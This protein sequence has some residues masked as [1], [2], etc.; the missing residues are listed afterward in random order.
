MGTLSV[1]SIGIRDIP[2]LHDLHS[3]HVEVGMSP[4]TTRQL[5]AGLLGSLPVTRRLRR[6]FVATLDD[7]LAALVELEPYPRD[8]RWLVT[9][10]AA[11]PSVDSEAGW[12]ELW[13]ELLLH[14]VR[15]AGQAGA[16]RLHA[17]P[18]PDG[19]AYE[20]LR[21]ASFN[22]YAQQT[23][24]LA[25]GVHLD[26]GVSTVVREQEPS[27]AWSIHQLYHVA[28]PY[29]IQHAEALTSNHW[30]ARRDAGCVVRGFLVD[31]GH[32]VAAYCRVRSRRRTHV[33]EILTLPEEAP[34]LASLLPESLRRAGVGSRDSVWVS[35]PDYQTEHLPYLQSLGFRPI[36]RQARMVRY[37]AVPVRSRAMPR[38]QLVPEVGER[39]A[40]RLP[41]LSSPR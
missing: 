12:V 9:R 20:A 10:L 18:P 14:A 11:S 27:D 32:Q 2:N 4:G 37:T 29:P 39:L 34:L 24:L 3:V 6:V 19:P 22:A 15:A 26:H 38:L 16:K 30:D 35:V 7:R 28:T 8:Y 1:R 21:R 33:L 23:T 36:D 40:P 13:S 31:R 41:S 5:S 17:A 25:Q